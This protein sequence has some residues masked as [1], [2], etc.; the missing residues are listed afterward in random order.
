MSRNLKRSLLRPQLFI[1]N[2]IDGFLPEFSDA[3]AQIENST[4]KT[5]WNK[6]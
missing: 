2:K 4:E 3:E 6:Y 1:E 5:L